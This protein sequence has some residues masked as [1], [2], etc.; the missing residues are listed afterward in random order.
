MFVKAAS[1]SQC[2]QGPERYTN[3]KMQ[4]SHS[5]FPSQAAEH[6]WEPANSHLHS[7]SLHGAQC[8]RANG[9]LRGESCDGDTWKTWLIGHTYF[10][11][12][13][14]YNLYMCVC[15][16][17]CACVLLLLGAQCPNPWNSFQDI[18]YGLFLIV[19]IFY[20]FKFH[21]ISCGKM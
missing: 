9:Q 17:V 6:K 14:L 1:F 16:C 18:T 3:H 21:Y 5:F 20:I 8:S 19:L 2:V 11:F 10:T 13:P 7:N 15:V 4:N 12:I